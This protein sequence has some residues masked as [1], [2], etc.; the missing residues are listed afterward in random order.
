[1]SNHYHLVLKIDIEQQQKL[2]SKAVISRWLQLFNGH[3]IAVDFLKEGQ[4]GTDK[5]QALSN[6]VK[7]W[8]Q[9]LGSISWFMRCLNEEIAR[10]AN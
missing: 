5:Q 10:K 8:L 1:M 9:R 7:E 2:T 6:L 4:V 3:P